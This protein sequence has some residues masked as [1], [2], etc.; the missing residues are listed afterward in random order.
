MPPN[1]RIYTIGGKK[2]GYGHIA[3]MIPIYDEFQEANCNCVFFVSGDDFSLDILEKRSS[4]VIDWLK[5]APQDLGSSDI[6]F[7]D[8]LDPPIE[9][10]RKVQKLTPNVYFICDK[11]KT[12][13]YP[14]N[15]INWRLGADKLT[16]TN[17]LYGEK[18]VPLRRELLEAKKIKPKPSQF[19]VVISMGSGDVQS[20]ISKTLELF[21][22]KIKKS[23]HFKVVIRS[24]HKFFEK[25]KT[26]Y[27]DQVTILADLSARELFASIAGSRFAIASGGHSIYE[28]AFLG[29][30][31]IHVL[32]S[33]NQKPAKCWDSSGFTY[34]IGFYDPFRYEQQIWNGI[35]YYMNDENLNKARIAGKALIDGK[36]AERIRE[37]IFKN[38]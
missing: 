22:P 16:A 37:N 34:P 2:F 27:G 36:G 29:I 14:F 30:P 13:A 26:T 9:F 19:E 21:L 8:T 38:I 20:L 32:V 11:L 33:D 25:I 5:Y 23:I 10:I 1:I 17:G 28:F 12:S 35:T 24:F 3:R 7:I 15:V 31:V 6:V 4:V 18:Y